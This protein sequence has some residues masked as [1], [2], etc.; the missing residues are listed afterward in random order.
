MKIQ[1]TVMDNFQ[2]SV[3][4]CDW[5]GCRAAAFGAKKSYST[6]YQARLPRQLLQGKPLSKRPFL[7]GS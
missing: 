5:T 1:K 7:P 3:L 2:V 6:T 4:T